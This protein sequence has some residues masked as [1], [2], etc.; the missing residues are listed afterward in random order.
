ME[1]QDITNKFMSD[2]CVEDSFNYIASK[3]IEFRHLNNMTQNDLAKKANI[4][5]STLSKIENKDKSVRFD[6]IIKVITALNSY[7]NLVD[8]NKSNNSKVDFKIH[9]NILCS[10]NLI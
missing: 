2:I 9:Y 5:R 10:S 7:I 3:I 8:L 1:W 6:N 4:S